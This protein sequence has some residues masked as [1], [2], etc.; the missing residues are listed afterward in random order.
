VEDSFFLRN[1]LPVNINDFMI[2][3]N[4]TSPGGKDVAMSEENGKY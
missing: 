3:R 4:C 1:A 2:I